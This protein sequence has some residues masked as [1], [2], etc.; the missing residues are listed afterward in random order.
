LCLVFV[1]STTHTGNAGGLDGADAICQD[2]A[3]AAGRPGSYRAWLSDDSGAP[4]TRFIRA[5][6]PY[7]LVNGDIVANSYADLTDGSLLNRAISVTETGMSGGFAPNEVWT[8]TGDDGQQQLAPDNCNS[9]TNGTAAFKG[10]FGLKSSIG[11]SWTGSNFRNCDQ[12]SRL[13]CF[14]QR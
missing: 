13:Y 12:A 10:D 7:V 8:S 3:V 2:L 5:S 4:S 9:W 1:S 6:V 14:Q 11:P